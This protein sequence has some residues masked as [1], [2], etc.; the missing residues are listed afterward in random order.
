MVA[1]V[2]SAHGMVQLAQRLD[3]DSVRLIDGTLRG[4]CWRAK[5]S[6]RGFPWGCW[7][8]GATGLQWG[9]AFGHLLRDGGASSEQRDFLFG[10]SG[11]LRYSSVLA[12][13]R[14]C[15]NIYISITASQLH[16]PSQLEGFLFVLGAPAGGHCR[17]AGRARAPPVETF[18]R[19]GGQIPKG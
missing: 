13:F 7:L 2:F 18:E 19:F 16:F 1:G 10:G 11:P 9:R 3:F 12:Q 8:A 14:R 5:T 6:N 4:W 15:L 17:T